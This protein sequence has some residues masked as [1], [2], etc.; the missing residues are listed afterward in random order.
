M[1]WANKSIRV[2]LLI[3]SILLLF[4]SYYYLPSQNKGSIK[5]ENLKNEEM[6]SNL[7]GVDKFKESESKN[8]FSDTEYVSQSEKGQIFTT[9]SKE[10][11]IFQDQPDLINLIKPYSFTRLE[12]DNS[13]LEIRSL[14]GLFDK[15]KNETIY[16]NNVII[17][18]KNYLITSNYAKHT[19]S[20]NIIIIS[21][22]V[23]MKDLTMGL[24]HIAF[25]D[26]VE[27]NTIT[28]NAIAYMNLE[29]EKVRA[30]KFK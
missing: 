3:F 21:G 29:E 13:L 5:I 2:I 1:H 9:K 22:N 26:K 15:L 17:K 28:N 23:V 19:S 4:Y 10:S 7:K 8:I 27:I 25:C 14:D 12:K 24:S 20:K 6:S 18:N 30:K 16:E 11:Y